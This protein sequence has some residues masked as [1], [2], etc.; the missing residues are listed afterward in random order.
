MFLTILKYL[1]AGN[2][3]EEKKNPEYY[4]EHN[5]ILKKDNGLRQFKVRGT[6]FEN[7]VIEIY[8]NNGVTPK[9][10]DIIVKENDDGSYAGFEI[11]ATNRL[12]YGV[13][14]HSYITIYQLKVRE[15]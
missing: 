5:F 15:F 4:G 13:G 11:I 1:F 12:E 8:D 14:E 6:L 9:R 2:K 10:D 3:E 7:D